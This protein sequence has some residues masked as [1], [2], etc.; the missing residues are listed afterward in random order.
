MPSSACG[1][2][3]R[4]Q[5]AFRSG[6]SFSWGRPCSKRKTTPSDFHCY[7]TGGFTYR[8]QPFDILRSF[9]LYYL[10][11][12]RCRKHFDGQ[13]SLKK[14]L[15]QAW[16]ATTEV[17]MAT[18]KAIRSSSQNRNQD[19]QINIEQAFKAKWLHGHI[20]GEGKA[21][22]SWRLLPPLYFLNF[23]ND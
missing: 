5:T 8:R 9:L 1:T 15:L 23:S 19:N 13:Y 11:S 12:E 16:E 4:R 10:W 3:G 6:L 17:S 14:V 22:I 7:H 21:A 2:N 18:W 20:F